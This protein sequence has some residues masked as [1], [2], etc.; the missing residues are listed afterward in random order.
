MINQEEDQFELLFEKEKIMAKTQFFTKSDK[1]LENYKNNFKKALQKIKIAKLFNSK[2]IEFLD[3]WIDSQK[4]YISREDVDNLEKNIDLVYKDKDF[5]EYIL[6]WLKRIKN[7]GNILEY[8]FNL[9]FQ[10]Y[11]LA[12]KYSE[13]K[14]KKEFDKNLEKQKLESKRKDK[15]EIEK[16]F[17]DL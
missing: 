3:K 9:I 8:S 15:E 14:K 6:D 13:Y 7:N 12:K 2:V 17:D 5:Y 1:N 11:E 16:L 4:S 10:F